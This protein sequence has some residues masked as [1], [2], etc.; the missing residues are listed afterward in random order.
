MILLSTG[1]RDSIQTERVPHALRPDCLARTPPPEGH[2]HPRHLGKEAGS[3]RRS[4]A[5]KR[6]QLRPK[7]TAPPALFRPRKT[8]QTAKV[9]VQRE[10][11]SQGGRRRLEA[12]EQSGRGYKTDETAYRRLHRL[13]Q[14]KHTEGQD[15]NEIRKGKTLAFNVW[16][17]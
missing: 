12:E 17:V 9:E 4:G 1:D 6:A 15:Q 8:R 16:F 13:V 14:D 10:R 3:G 7:R 5:T 2:R 11:R